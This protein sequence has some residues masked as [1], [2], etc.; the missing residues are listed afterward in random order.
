ML[1]VLFGGKTKESVL[2]YLLAKDE[3]YIR[4]IASFYETSS[5]VVKQQIDKLEQ[6][7]VIVG[8]DIGNIRMYRL[9]PR[10]P[11][12]KELISLLERAR[13]AYEP[14]LLKKLLENE[15][16]RPRRKGKPVWKK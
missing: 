5:T 3:G 11:F 14:D 8:K 7:G 12:L 4:G 15:R 9:N 13:E 16:V 10:Y 6:G 2:Q 1:E